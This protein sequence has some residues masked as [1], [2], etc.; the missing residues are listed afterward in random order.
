MRDRGGILFLAPVRLCWFG[1]R[2]R[3]SRKP[4]LV[5]LILVFWFV[6]CLQ[7]GHAQMKK[8]SF[9][10][11][12]LWC[13]KKPL[14]QAVLVLFYVFHFEG[15]H[16]SRRIISGYIIGFVH[17]LSVERYGGFDAFYIKLV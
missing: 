17:Q 11:G 14:L 13:K 7:Q 6:N 5:A 2:K 9:T 12:W 10:L 4:G 3:Y 1:A 15:F 16:E 8:N